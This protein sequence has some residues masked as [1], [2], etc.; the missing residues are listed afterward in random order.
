MW[1]DQ[2]MFADG[3]LR[4]AEG[5]QIFVTEELSQSYWEVLHDL[6]PAEWAHAVRMARQDSEMPPG[7]IWT[8]GK[9]HAWG[10]SYLDPRQDLRLAVPGEKA[11]QDSAF[12]RLPGES[13]LAYV[14]RYASH[15]KGQAVSVKAMPEVARLPYKEPE[16]E[17]DRGDDADAY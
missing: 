2:A 17:I 15:L 16:E 13:A 4:L 10:K 8:P 9:L 6:T 11:T 3:F 12:P 7:K 5:Q 1:I 14:Q